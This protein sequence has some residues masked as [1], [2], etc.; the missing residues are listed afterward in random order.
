MEWLGL[1][2][3]VVFLGTPLLI[4]GLLGKKFGPGQQRRKRKRQVEA[5][6]TRYSYDA[7]L[8]DEVLDDMRRDR[9]PRRRY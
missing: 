8:F 7:D 4:G 5:A 1:F 3:I 9:R 6:L 2:W